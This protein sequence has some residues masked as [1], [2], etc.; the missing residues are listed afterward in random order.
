MSLLKMSKGRHKSQ[1]QHFPIMPAFSN[2][3]CFAH[4]VRKFSR[5]AEVT[6]TISGGRQTCQTGIVRLIFMDMGHGAWA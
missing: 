2:A 4:Y 3:I 6:L 5:L 1:N